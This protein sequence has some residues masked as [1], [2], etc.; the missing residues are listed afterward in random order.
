ME[1]EIKQSAQ[2]TQSKQ[3]IHDVITTNA[4]TF[5]D[6]ASPLSSE[7]QK[8]LDEAKTCTVDIDKEIGD[9]ERSADVVMCD[10][11]Q[12]KD[13]LKHGIGRKMFEEQVKIIRDLGGEAVSDVPSLNC[14]EAKITHSGTLSLPNQ[15]E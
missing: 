9:Q 10:M 5:T 7:H 3:V 11:Q 4:M 13:D 8:I 12:R 15:Q 1:G 14:T 2:N 6:P